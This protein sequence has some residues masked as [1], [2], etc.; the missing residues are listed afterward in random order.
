MSASRIEL[1]DEAEE[2][3]AAEAI[4]AARNKEELV[5]V[6]WDSAEHFA[7]AARERLQEEY[8]IK[9]RQF[10]PMASAG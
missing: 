8:A 2:R 3:D 5:S 10:A 4:R 6:W 9:V 7:G 1:A